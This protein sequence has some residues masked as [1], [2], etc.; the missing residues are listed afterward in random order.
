MNGQ[1]LLLLLF[2]D[3]KQAFDSVDHTALKIT[4]QRFGIP[5]DIQTLIN[6][7]YSDPTFE[8]KGLNG[9]LAQGKVRTG[10]RQGC[11]LS[12]YLFVIILSVMFEDV[13]EALLNAGVATNTWSVNYPTYDVEYADDTLLLGLTTPQLE[14]MLHQVESEAL[15]YGMSLNSSKTEILYKASCSAPKVRFLNGTP[16]PTTTQI[17]YLGTMVSWEHPFSVAFKH[18][19]ALAEQAYKKLRLLWNS[20]LPQKVKLRIFQSTFPAVLTYGLDAFT[21]DHKA[22]QR[23]DGC[24]YRFLRRIVNIPATYISRIPNSV[25][26]LKANK[27]QLPSE[28]LRNLQLKLL[29][30]VFVAPITD[31]IHNVVMSAAFRDRI[32]TKGRRRGRGSGWL[33]VTT[34]REFPDIW[35]SDHTARFPHHQYIGI[36]RKLSS[37]SSGQAPKCARPQGT[38]H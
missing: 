22:L 25:V 30:E 27:P 21:L 18:R 28:S 35:K 5:E 11:P 16:V 26:Y 8:I 1:T 38:R 3:W 7:I 37:L 32:I 31:P 9:R 33:E 17:K 24:Y 20:S 12:P 23:I 19:A 10:I 6:S 4:L 36:K 15:L 13:D 14:K 2:L 29:T 34:K